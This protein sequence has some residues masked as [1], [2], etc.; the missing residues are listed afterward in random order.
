MFKKIAVG[1]DGS[2]HSFKALV[3]AC[4]IAKAL[5]IDKIEV[6]HVIPKT[7]PYA[8]PSTYL[9]APDAQYLEF[10]EEVGRNALNHAEQIAR[11][12]GVTIEK[13]LLE[14]NPVEELVKYAEQEKIDLLV[15]GRRGLGKEHKPGIGSVSLAVASNTQRSL[16]I[17]H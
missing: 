2:L 8:E 4:H 7:P 6:I 15:L 3:A 10:L 1:I 9:A 17:V 16:L 12:H 14:G 13:I 5:N 11:N